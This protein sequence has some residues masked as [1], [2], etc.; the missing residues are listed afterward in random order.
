VVTAIREWTSVTREQFEQ[1]IQPIDQPAVFRG[2]VSDWPTVGRASEPI[3]A[4]IDFL[5]QH[6]SG[7]PVYTVVGQ[8]DIKG[9]FFY[10]DALTGVNFKRANVEFSA[11]VEQIAALVDQ[12]DPHAIAIQS[13]ELRDTLPDLAAKHGMPLIDADVSP[14]MWLGNQAMVAPHYDAY[15][16]LAAVVY[17]RRSFTLFPPDQVANLYVGP[18]LEA[19][20]GVPI[21]LVDLRNP[22]FEKWPKFSLALETAQTAT[23]EPGDVIYIPS[24]WWHAVESLEPFNMLVNYWWTDHPEQAVSPNNSLMMAMLTIANLSPEKRRSWKEF[25]DYYVFKDTGDAA[26]HLPDDLHDVV[27]TL[28][29]EQ[30]TMLRAFLKSK[31]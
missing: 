24:P 6:D 17:G 15:D 22:D 2:L 26:K 21:S 23:L 11:V 3:R 5:K 7:K 30:S 18:A 14:T 10:N 27:T 4:F 16:N 28:T 8:P 19:P 31:L 1:E 12:P 13:A 25:F 20:G 9:R 29:P